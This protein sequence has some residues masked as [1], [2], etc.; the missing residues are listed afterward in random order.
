MNRDVH[1]IPFC[2]HSA[3]LRYDIGLGVMAMN[4]LS[5]FN[6]DHDFNGVCPL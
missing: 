2:I 5:V 1:R 6:D 4:M 3:S